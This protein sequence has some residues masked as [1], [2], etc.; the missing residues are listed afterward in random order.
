VVFDIS[1][2][3]PEAVIGVIAVVGAVAILV[4]ALWQ[5]GRA[6]LRATSWFWLSAG[7]IL[8]AVF[9]VHNIGVP[10]GLLLGGAPSIPALAMAFLAWRDVEL[11]LD[12]GHHPRARSVS[13]V[14]AAA[15]LLLISLGGFQQ[16]SAFD[17]ARRLEAGDAT[18]ATGAVQDAQGNDGGYE[19]FTV[20]GYRYCYNDGPTSVG[21][22]QTAAYGGPIHNGLQV[23]VSSIGDV[24]VRLE[25]AD[26][27]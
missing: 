12:E 11:R 5:N 24:I 17:L 18:V 19:C 22:H 7:G 6:F 26:G 13:P 21:F 23:R 14:V 20:G 25:I 2:R 1:E 27:Q 15:L 9:S 3:F 8:W 4:L 10:Y 16:L